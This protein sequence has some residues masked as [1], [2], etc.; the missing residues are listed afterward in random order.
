MELLQ[1]QQ[2]QDSR[3]TKSKLKVKDGLPPNK[4][5]SLTPFSQAQCQISSFF[6]I[7]GIIIL[8]MNT[9][10]FIKDA[11]DITNIGL[12]VTLILS[13]W[14]T[15]LIKQIL[16]SNPAKIVFQCIGY[17]QEFKWYRNINFLLY[18]SFASVLPQIF[19]PNIQG[20]VNIRI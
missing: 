10:K 13:L 5:F 3:K 4:R 15:T 20:V 19:I 8:Q 14:L 1:R 17:P 18:L 6:K 12:R 7:E 16:R 2:L 11:L 9:R